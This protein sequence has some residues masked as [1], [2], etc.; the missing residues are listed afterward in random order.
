MI[1]KI[2]KEIRLKINK[3]GSNFR[4]NKLKIK[5]PTIISNNCWA[6]IVSQYLGIKYYTPTIGLYFF[7]EEYIR[8]LENFD[9]YIEQDLKIIKTKDSKYYDEMINKNHQDA[10]I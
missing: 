7:S 2:L 1:K 10:I 8:F 5:N 3:I 4:R 6:G 9:Y